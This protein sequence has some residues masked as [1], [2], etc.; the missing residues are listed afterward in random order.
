MTM[1]ISPQHHSVVLGKQNN[2]LKSIMHRTN[3]QIM[4]PD[5]GDPNIPNLKKSNVT[6]TGSITNVY[7]AR[8]QLIGSLPL[9]L[10]FDLP[11][12]SVTTITTDDVTR[13]MQSLDV[14]INIRHK[15]KQSTLSIV[16]KGI[17][18]NANNIYEARRRLLGLE[19][20]KVMAEIPS[21]YIVSDSFSPFLANGKL[22]RFFR[23]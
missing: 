9:I 20:P 4:F 21:T 3:T 12:K 14:V 13:L 22:T 18:R 17:E 7:L 2:N 1:E 10:M 8:Q 5:A 23:T 6:I 16:I 19:E 15:P 11:E